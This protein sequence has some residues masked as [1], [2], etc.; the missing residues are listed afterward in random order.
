ADAVVVHK[1]SVRHLSPERFAEMS[2]IIHLNA[3][4]SQAHDPDAKYVVTEVEEALRLGA[5]AVSVHVNVGSDDERQQIGDLGRIAD[6]CDRWNLP[7]LAMV[8]PRGPRV[9]DPRDPRL[10]AHAVTV[11]A[12]LG[13]DLVKTVFLGSVAEMLDLTAACPVPV[14]VA[15]G[16]AMPT[17]EDVLAY[18]RDALAGGAGGV[19]MG[20]NIFQAADPR[21][22]ASEVARL[23]HHFPEHHFGTVALPDTGAPHRDERLTPDHLDDA[24]S[25]P[26]Y[27][28]HLSAAS[29]PT[30]GPH[31]DGRKTVLA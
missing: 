15:G 1:G 8:Y 19:A 25:L 29:H 30:G 12:E 21:R 2:L 31:H 5:D 22:L 14:L 4:T 18:V 17:E 26:D 24:V 9:A 13:A 16:P 7:L 27:A 23:I 28:H 10:V 20:R 6:A 3:S 11:A